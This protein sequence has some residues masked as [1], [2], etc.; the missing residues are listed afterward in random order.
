MGVYSNLKNKIKGPHARQSLT[1]YTSMMVGVLVSLGVS[2]VNT[3]ALGPEQF[4][5]FKFLQNMFLFFTTCTTFGFFVAGGR[6]MTG[7][8]EGLDG[9]RLLAGMSLV[10]AGVSVL[11]TV[12]V[13]IFSIFEEQ[14][15]DN[16]LSYLIRL[17]A[18]LIFALPLHN[19]VDNLL[20]GANEIT[21]LSFFRILPS[22]LYLVISYVIYLFL[23]LSLETAILLH[24]VTTAII[25][26]VFIINRK[27]VWDHVRNEVDRII[28]ET[29]A[30][31]FH[32]Y[33]GTLASVATTQFAGFALGYFVDNVAVGFYLLARTITMPLAAVSTSIGTVL[34]RSFANSSSIPTRIF[35]EVVGVSVVLYAIFYVVIDWLVGVLY[36]PEYSAVIPLCK[37]LALAAVLH[38]IGDLVN[39]FVCAKGY[40][41]FSRNASFM[42]GGL[43]VL[44]FTVLVY[45]FG[46]MGAAV[47][48]IISGIGFMIVISGYYQKIKA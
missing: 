5:D 46:T 33:I 34:Y 22:L 12:V 35:I 36:T 41:Q 7:T 45:Y 43:N 13:V 3:R 20:V 26:L 47:T 23:E 48:S 9:R 17:S 19:C 38:G 6:M 21:K 39:K 14:I 15:F 40:G 11:L 4:G 37:V 16:D 44:G 2:M 42:R 24:L 25:A 27:P 32:V 18:P 28:H 10:A 1:L 8:S 29:R 31:G 30:F